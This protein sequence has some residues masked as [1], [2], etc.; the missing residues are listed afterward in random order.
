MSLVEVFLIG[1][2]V[3][4]DAFAVSICKGLSLKKLTIK[5]SIIIALYFSIFQALMPLI[6]F[7]L[8]TAFESFITDIDHWLAFILLGLIG[9]NMLREAFSQQEEINDKLDFKTMLLL[10]VATS[11]DAL[12]IGITFAFL[13]TNIW[14][15]ILIIGITT[16]IISFIGVNMGHKFGAKHQKGAEIL[17]GFILILMGIKIL[18]EHLNII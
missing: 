13:Q 4:M 2:G 11:I 6:G 5:Q 14:I 16:L 15:N 8:G 17:G 3:S 7:F 9:I 12:A 10:S 1:V 18:L